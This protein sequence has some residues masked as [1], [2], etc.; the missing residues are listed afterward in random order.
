VARWTAVGVGLLLLVAPLVSAEVRFVYR[1]GWELLRIQWRATSITGLL[2][3]PALD[4]AT[5]SQLTLVLDARSF[6]VDSLALNADKSFTR[7]VDIGRDTLVLVLSASPHDRLAAYT[8]WFPITG[9][10]SYHG[11]Y[12]LAAAER[13]AARFKER[14]YDTYL[15]TAGAFSTLGWLPDPLFSTSVGP[16]PWV[17]VTVMH[18]LAHNTVWFPGETQ[19]S[20]SLADL[21]G[22]RGAEQFFRSRGDTTNARRMVQAWEHNRVLSRIQMSLVAA[23]R[24]ALREGREPDERERR[25]AAAF[26]AADS[27]I[28]SS[29]INPGRALRVAIAEYNNAA[30]IAA[31]LYHGDLDGLEA[32][33]QSCGGILAAVTAAV[34]TAADPSSARCSADAVPLSGTPS[35]H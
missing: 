32:L 21:I 13:A 23:L 20:E 7:Y 12:S 16:G 30:V 34:R 31:G 25:R 17:A 27:S 9:R 8:W 14:G 29:G 10:V 35:A 15:R 2:Q 5:R 26:T 33:Y 1:G 18:E 28:Q 19:F 6:A 24:E 4:S 22:Y 3:D 11:Y